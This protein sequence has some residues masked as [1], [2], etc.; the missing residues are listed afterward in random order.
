MA[1]PSPLP[2]IGATRDEVR[3]LMASLGQPAYR[4]DQLLRWVYAA[5]ATSIEAMTDMP[6]ALRATLAEWTRL[7]TTSVADARQSSD[8]TRKLLVA[9][10]IAGNPPADGERIETVIIPEGR[11][12]TVCVSTQVGCAVG[13][14]FCASGL[15]G[16]VRDLSAGE[17]VEQ[18]LHARR[19]I[20]P[21]AGLT[22]VVVMG[23]GEPLA[24]YDA[25]AAALRLL[26]A[27]WA[28]A[29]S[30]RRITVSTVGLP[31]RI[32]RLAEEGLG[33]NLAVSLH[34]ADDVTRR[35]L[36]PGARPIREVVA[37]ARDYLRMTGREV[38]L[39]YVLV[40][41][42]NDS[43]EDARGLAEVVG[44]ERILVNLLPL[45]PVAG[46]LLEE[47]PPGRAERFA[48]ELKSKGVRVQRRRRRGADIEGACGQLRHRAAEGAGPRDGSRG[49]ED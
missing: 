11:R 24:N 16:L 6:K 21:P 22:H 40:K 13:C 15:G 10:R 32:R 5:G 34:A 1:Q 31:D 7:Y 37:A 41:G 25:L 2:L 26:T 27:P 9:L 19:C 35:R 42:V 46:L 28:L 47:S 43:L 8:G 38:T 48:A 29:L 30:P 18:V 33:V 12:A 20:E 36:I 14:A 39:E 44:R 49:Q 45:N 17:I 23:I 3:A 4:A